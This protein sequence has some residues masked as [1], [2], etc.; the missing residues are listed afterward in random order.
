VR[1]GTH[2]LNTRRRV[3]L[4]TGAKDILTTLDTYDHLLPSLEPKLS[5]LLDARYRTALRDVT[6]RNGCVYLSLLT[7]AAST[8][9]APAT[10]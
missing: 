3:R 2:S 7:A 10:T 1:R 5:D 6:E 8:P 9:R 4:R